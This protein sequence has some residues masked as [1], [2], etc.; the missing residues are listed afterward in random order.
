LG[1]NACGIYI[2]EENGLS[3]G[4]DEKNNSESLF[5]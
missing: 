3:V 5:K 4:V 1:L 2:E